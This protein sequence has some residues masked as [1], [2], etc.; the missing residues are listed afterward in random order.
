MTL[1]LQCVLGRGEDHVL[2][3]PLASDWLR[4]FLKLLAHALVP[5]GMQPHLFPAL[6]LN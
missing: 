3:G 2:E 1:G 4:I 5:L 6:R